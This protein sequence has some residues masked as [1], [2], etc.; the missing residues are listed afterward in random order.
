MGKKDYVDVEEKLPIGKTIPLSLQH[1]F[2][3]GGATI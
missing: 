3:M 2:A 1:L